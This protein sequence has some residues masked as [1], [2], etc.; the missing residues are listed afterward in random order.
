MTGRIAVLTAST[1]RVAGKSPSRVRVDGWH[2]GNLMGRFR[3]LNRA[4]KTSE[5]SC[6]GRTTGTPAEGGEDRPHDDDE[7]HEGEACSW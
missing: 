6:K 3:A 1:R 4:L 2:H 5:A 7:E